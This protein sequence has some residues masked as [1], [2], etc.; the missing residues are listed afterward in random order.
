MG[1]RR[2]RLEFRMELRAHKERMILDFNYLNQILFRIHPNH[3][4]TSF[5]KYGPKSIIKLVAMP[6]PLKNHCF[7]I[8]LRTDCFWLQ[9]AL[10]F[11]QSHGATVL[12]FFQKLGLISHNVNHILSA[13]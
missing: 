13:L 8:S 10:I 1:M 7:T 11:A 6:V 12:F 4:K 5:F 9:S 2:P 3:N